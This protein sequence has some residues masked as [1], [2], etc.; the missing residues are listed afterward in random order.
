MFQPLVVTLHDGTAIPVGSPH[1]AVAGKYVVAI[2]D[3][4]GLMYNIPYTAILHVTQKD[5]NNP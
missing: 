5:E 1:D 4:Q 2:R 3:A